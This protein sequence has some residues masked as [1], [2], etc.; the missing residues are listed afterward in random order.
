MFHTLLCSLAKKVGSDLESLCITGWCLSYR[1][2]GF[3]QTNLLFCRVL[4]QFVHFLLK[5]WY[6]LNGIELP[7][8]VWFECDNLFFNSWVFLSMWI[9]CFFSWEV[10]WWTLPLQREVFTFP[11]ILSQSLSEGIHNFL[12]SFFLLPLCQEEFPFL[13]EIFK[14]FLS[15]EC[16]FVVWLMPPRLQKS[17]SKHPAS[18]LMGGLLYLTH[19]L[20]P[21]SGVFR[22][23]SIISASITCSAMS[24]PLATCLL[25]HTDQ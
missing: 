13:L 4:L 10:S 2:P 11:I 22:S 12:Y 24:Q 6:L 15:N 23:C 21:Y 20:T 16:D 17:S 3:L 5:F 18:P 14:Q 8:M 25:S 1:L 7:A 19:T 9:H